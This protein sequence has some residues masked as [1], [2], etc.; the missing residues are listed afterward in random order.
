MQTLGAA[1]QK[2]LERFLNPVIF[3]SAVTDLRLLKLPY[4][5]GRLESAEC[6]KNFRRKSLTSS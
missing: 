6:H 3:C 5:G 4:K 2:L 1:D